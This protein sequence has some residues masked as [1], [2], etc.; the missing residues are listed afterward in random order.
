LPSNAVIVTPFSR[1]LFFYPSIRDWFK[2][3]NAKQ[4]KQVWMLKFG[5][6]DLNLI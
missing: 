5:I 3:E 4:K 6:Q 2:P 1:S